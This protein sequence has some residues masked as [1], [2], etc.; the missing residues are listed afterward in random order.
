MNYTF[1][2][3]PKDLFFYNE[4]DGNLYYLI[5]FEKSI[6]SDIR[7]LFGE[8]FLKKYE[9]VFNQDSKK[10]GIYVGK[11]IEENNSWFSENKWYIIL[12]IVLIILVVCLVLISYQYLQIIRRRKKANELTDDYDYPIND[13]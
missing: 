8:A 9:F 11:K 12:I 4:K 5:E 3:K 13:E 6:I 2:Y 10:I 7:W 1:E